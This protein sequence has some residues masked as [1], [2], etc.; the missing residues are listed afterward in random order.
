MM[1]FPA[2]GQFCNS[3]FYPYSFISHHTVGP[4]MRAAARHCWQVR[5]RHLLHT[6]SR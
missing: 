5:F 4:V 3:I 1:A 2:G 6:I